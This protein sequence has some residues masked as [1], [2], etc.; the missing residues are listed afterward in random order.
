MKKKMF[1]IFTLIALFWGACK[2]ESAEPTTLFTSEDQKAIETLRLANNKALKEHNAAGVVAAY[3]DTFFILTSTNGLTTGKLNVQNVYQS[4]FTSR[5]D[6][7]FVRTPTAIAVNNEW[8]MASENGNWKGTW[9]VNGE[10]IA[11][12]GDYYAKWHKINGTWKLRCE[13]YTQ[14]MCSG[15]VVCNNKPKLE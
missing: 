10:A 13:V 15:A 1:L 3:V 2:K 12:G 5:P 4:V 8:N 9:T 14:L 7:L 11:V 6:V